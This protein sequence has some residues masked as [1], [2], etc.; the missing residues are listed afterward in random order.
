MRVLTDR[1]YNSLK[2]DTF[3]IHHP[4]EEKHRTQIRDGIHTGKDRD[5]SVGPA[6]HHFSRCSNGSKSIPCAVLTETD[7]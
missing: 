4:G 7:Q 1:Y 6:E 3:L 5:L 2:T